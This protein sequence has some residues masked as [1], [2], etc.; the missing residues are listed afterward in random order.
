[1]KISKCRLRW[2]QQAKIWASATC[3]P[4]Y[5]RRKVKP[6]TTMIIQEVCATIIHGNIS[7]TIQKSFRRPSGEYDW[8][9]IPDKL[10]S[11]GALWNNEKT[12]E[13]W[14]CV[15]VCIRDWQCQLDCAGL[16]P[17]FQI[18]AQAGPRI[19]IWSKFESKHDWYCFGPIIS[20]TLP[21]SRELLSVYSHIPSDDD[22]SSKPLL[23]SIDCGSILEWQVN[24]NWSI[25]IGATTDIPTAGCWR[26][27]SETE[28]HDINN[29]PEIERAP[30]TG[31]VLDG[32]DET[33]WYV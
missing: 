12:I 22:H 6:T 24:R 9:I 8:A 7:I 31:P 30:V 26:S 33:V 18:W 2:P 11:I 17:S 23:R 32:R 13:S 29:A 14:E 1:M 3:K 27:A 10:V 19:L 25:T 20:V 16:P 15:R 5:V 28:C 4:S 21:D